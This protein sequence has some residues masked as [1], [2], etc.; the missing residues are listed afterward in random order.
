MQQGNGKRAGA[1][2]E[3]AGTV[4]SMAADNPPNQGAFRAAGALP[5]LL[6]LILTADKPIKASPDSFTA[7]HGQVRVK[8]SEVL[9][10]SV[11]RIP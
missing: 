8:R 6:S 11:M 9:L 7:R 2:E 1:A 5:L 3:A 10:V 4:G